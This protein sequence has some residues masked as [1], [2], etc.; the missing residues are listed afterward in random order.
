MDDDIVVSSK[1]YEK[2][3][4]AFVDSGNALV[5]PFVRFWDPR[6]SEYKFHDVIHSGRKIRYSFAL[7]KLFLAKTEL[8][9]AF[10]CLGPRSL[11]SVIDEFN[12]C[13][14]LALNF[15]H[16]VL[17]RRCPMHTYIHV[18]DYGTGHAPAR[19]QGVSFRKKSDT[20]HVH[21]RTECVRRFS[22][23]FEVFPNDVQCTSSVSSY[24]GEK[25][26]RAIYDKRTDLTAG[27]VSTSAIHG[28]VMLI[29]FALGLFLLVALRTFSPRFRWKTF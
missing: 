23:I 20:V 8:L 28:V 22:K 15:V 25:F 7:T 19:L 13:E 18:L 1:D 4:N 9:Q 29:T 3:Y 6:R 16:W 24:G 2:F 17:Y 5:S 10:L 26:V 14:D 11:F 21:A 12:Q 27:S